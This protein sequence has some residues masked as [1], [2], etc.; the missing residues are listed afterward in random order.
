M[1]TIKFT[2]Y[3]EPVAKARAR[4]TFKHGKTFAYTP[5]KTKEAQYNFQA[6]SLAFKPKTPFDCPIALRVVVYRSIPK[7]FSENKRLQAEQGIIRPVTR[8]DGDNYLKLVCDSMNKIFWNDD[9]Q[10]VDKSVSK[11]YSAT[12][13]IEIELKTLPGPDSLFGGQSAA[14]ENK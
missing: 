6:Q 12:P 7:S 5:S 10:V 1:N 4:V 2:V 3:G 9:S 14:V 11:F 8:P 13:R